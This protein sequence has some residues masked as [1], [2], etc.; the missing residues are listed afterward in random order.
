MGNNNDFYS[1]LGIYQNAS[2]M[3]ITPKATATDLQNGLQSV[4]NVPLA[5]S[6]NPSIGTVAN[7]SDKKPLISSQTW[8][9]ITQLTAGGINAANALMQGNWTAKALRAQAKANLSQIGYNNEAMWRQ[10]MYMAEENL[11]KQELLLQERDEMLGTQMAGIGASGFDISA[12]EQRILQDTTVKYGRDFD[13][14]NRTVYCASVELERET[15]MENLRLETEA[16]LLKSQAKYAKKMARV[17][18]IGS[19]VSGLAGAA[20]SYIGGSGKNITVDGK[21]GG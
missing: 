3:D 21:W 1:A 8:G 11:S 20:G 15:M 7:T 6:T 19:F 18:A 12:G 10:Q 16:K 14:Q 13:T 17:S 2:V 9:A 5:A 4:S